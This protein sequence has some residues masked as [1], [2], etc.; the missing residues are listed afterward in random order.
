MIKI[1]IFMVCFVCFT[2]CHAQSITDIPKSDSSFPAIKNAL[3]LGYLTLFNDNTFRGD[4]SISRR[5]LAITIDKLSKRLQQKQLNLTET[6]REDLTHF[7]VDLQSIFG[8]LNRQIL[9]LEKQVPHLEKEQTDL[10]YDFTAMQDQLSTQI[11]SLEK[12]SK[13]QEAA[14]WALSVVSLLGLIIQ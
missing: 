4:V 10:H 11:V 7:V 5:E 3:N 2:L 9:T 13:F 12:K 6:Q 14:I 1:Y 8:D